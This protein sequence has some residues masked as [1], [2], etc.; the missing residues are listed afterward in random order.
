MVIL[1][2]HKCGIW[3]C[4]GIAV[5]FLAHNLQ[6]SFVLFPPL[7]VTLQLLVFLLLSTFPLPAAMHKGNSLCLS[8]QIFSELLHVSKSNR[9]I[10]RTLH[11]RQI[12]FY[13]PTP[14]KSVPACSAFQLGSVQKANFMIC[15]SLCLQH[16][17]ILVKQVFYR[18]CMPP[19]KAGKAAVVRYFFISQQP[20]KVY[21]VPASF[22]QVSVTVDTALVS[23]AYYFEHHL[24]IGCRFSTFGRIRFVQFPVVQFLKLCAGQPYRCCLW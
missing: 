11:L 16:L 15:F 9:F 4:F 18:F 13:S 1:H 17:D 5:P 8:R 10:Y 19:P 20:H 22:F 2:P 24:C 23:I 12:L 3:V 6:L 21:S 7:Q 14:Y